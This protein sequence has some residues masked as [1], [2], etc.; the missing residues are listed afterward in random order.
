MQ[1]T[2][3]TGGYLADDDD[4]YPDDFWDEETPHENMADAAV[5]AFW[6][7]ILPE[8]DKFMASLRPKPT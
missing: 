5:N 2:A 1:G 7:R 6:K 8:H 4:E 3:S